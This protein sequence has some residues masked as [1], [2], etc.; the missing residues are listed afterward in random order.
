MSVV[1]EVPNPDPRKKEICTE[2]KK[3]RKPL[4]GLRR[5]IMGFKKVSTVYGI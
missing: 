5:R 2:T 1:I 3:M 4:I